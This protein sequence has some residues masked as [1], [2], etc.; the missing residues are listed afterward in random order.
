MINLRL[1]VPGLNI[2]FILL[3]LSGQK[4]SWWWFIRRQKGELKPELEPKIKGKFQV[5]LKPAFAPF[6]EFKILEKP[7]HKPWV[8][9]VSRKCETHFADVTCFSKQKACFST[10]STKSTTQHEVKGLWTR[11]KVWD[12][13]R[14]AWKRLDAPMM[15]FFG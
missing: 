1:C 9:K 12:Q 6:L 11:Q 8:H 13:K 7:E 10:T 5:P 14:R 3:M 4:T 2:C 15:T